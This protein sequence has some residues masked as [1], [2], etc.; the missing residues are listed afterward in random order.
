MAN[1]KRWLQSLHW[2]IGIIRA[3]LAR[4]GLRHGAMVTGFFLLMTGVVATELVP[5]PL[6][7]KAGQV[8]RR[9]IAA[10]RRVLDRYQTRLLQEEA[11]KQAVREVAADPRNY[12]V[13]AAVAVQAEERLTS[14]TKALEAARA[15]REGGTSLSPAKRAEL[16]AAIRDK[17]GI[18]LRDTT[19]AQALGLKA[20]EWRALERALRETVLPALREERI[21]PENLADV[22]QG[23]IDRLAGRLEGPASAVARELVRALVIP[24]LVLDPQRVSRAQDAAVRAVKPV[25]VEKGQVILRR[26]DLVR[27]E[28]VE[29]LRDLGLVDQGPNYGRFAG[30]LLVMAAL[31]GLIAVYVRQYVPSLL[32]SDG[33][34]VMLGLLLLV[35]S[36]LA[37]AITVVPVP[38]AVYLMPTAL[39]S[40]LIAI[41]LDARLAIV[42]SLFLAV[43][44]GVVTEQDFRAVVI[45]LGSGL[46]AVLSVSRVS[47]RSGLTRAGLV[48][49]AVTFFTMLAYGLLLPDGE[50][51]RFAFLGLVNGIVSAVGAIGV[52]PY[53]ESV[54][55]ITSPLRLLELSN[56]NHPLLRRLLL[57]APGT[58]HH[59]I[60]VGNLAEAAAQAIG[61]DG[62]LVRV[63]ALYHDV[64]K[65]KRPYFFIE[66]QF[67]GEN[68][69][70]RISPSLSTLIILSHVKD[71][72]ELARQYRLPEVLVDFIR[73][74]HGT[75]LIKYFY[76]RALAQA[77]GEPVDE[78]AYRYPG[79]KPQSR[80]QAILMLA[81]SV[82][83][84][85]RSLSR[86]T[87]GRIEALV[88]K[89][90][91][92][93][94]HDGQL[95]ESDLTLRDLERIAAA[96]VRVLSGLFHQRVEYPERLLQTGQVEAGAADE[97]LRATAQAGPS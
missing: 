66:N 32:V 65:I 62:L 34:L 89:I 44:V 97:W 96:F 17:T 93:R 58:Y 48:V 42:G 25:F 53:L 26:G 4:R 30:A 69:H 52:L 49:G 60:M 84:A 71:G 56:P 13:N 1:S 57:E 83:A 75:D 67:G 77:G 72:V 81:D 38:G 43:V 27:P 88:R 82:E 55:G 11:A 5:E 68:P 41:L 50:L 76:H 19:L 36:L 18:D 70:D 54:F 74:H 14:L 24:N 64:G 59:S 39:V 22:R 61:A 3:G 8:A 87:S 95:D 10:P 47:Q 31:T 86:P 63:G 51:V 20:S 29:L 15:G 45:A 85:T 21:G 73:Q 16:A 2:F 33:Q 7:L 12:L 91:K 94:L 78:K 90:I 6:D 35:G 92:E 80:E 40:M 79:P 37:R 46:T 23:L 28:D 9:D